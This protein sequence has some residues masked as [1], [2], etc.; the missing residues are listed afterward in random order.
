MLGYVA[1]D[2]ADKALEIVA[3]NEDPL[4]AFGL[5]PGIHRRAADVLVAHPRARCGREG[6]GGTGLIEIAVAV[7][8]QTFE[9]VSRNRIFLNAL[10]ARDTGEQCNQQHVTDRARTD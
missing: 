2:L 4:C 6:E 5:L 10:A 3:Q 8:Q 7:L 9:L 1:F